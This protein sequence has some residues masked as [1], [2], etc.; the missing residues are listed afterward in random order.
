MAH[1]AFADKLLDLAENRSKEIAEH[2]YKAVIANRRTPSYHTLPKEMCILEAASF[3]K[4]LKQLYFAENPYQEVLKLLEKTRYVED[5]Y[6]KGIPLPEAIYALI[7]MRR[8]IWL[9]AEFQ[10][11]FVTS[12][13][14]YQAIE[15]INRTILIFDYAVYIVTQ[16]YYDMNK[17]KRMF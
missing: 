12:M 17:T 16:N 13:D 15:S 5:V 3:Y 2:W 4:N 10:A 6:T 7:M 1:R 8:H 11:M 9:Y 14:M